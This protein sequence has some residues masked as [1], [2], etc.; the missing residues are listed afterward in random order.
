[1]KIFKYLASLALL[2]G[3]CSAQASIV[4]AEGLTYY[5]NYESTSA[6]AP[7]SYVIPYWVQGGP[8]VMD[9]GYYFDVGTGPN[10]ERIGSGY[11]LSIIGWVPSW[12]LA[13]FTTSSDIVLQ[14]Y[15][16]G[17]YSNSLINDGDFSV[18]FY[19]LF[20]A[21]TSLQIDGVNALLVDANGGITTISGSLNPVPIPAAAWLMLSGIGVMGAAA[22]RRKAKQEIS[23]NP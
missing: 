9:T 3:T 14:P 1:M 16:L 22:R 10:Y 12:G 18:R 8:W 7:I 21:A 15:Q 20:G 2:C 19:N 23:R 13:P 4:M 11:S 17:K 6:P 5:F